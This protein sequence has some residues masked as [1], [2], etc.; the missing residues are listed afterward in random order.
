MRG[1][2]CSSFL[3][4][5]REACRGDGVVRT[6]ACVRVVRGGGDGHAVQEITEGRMPRGTLSWGAGRRKRRCFK[7]NG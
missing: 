4:A 5:M 2:A 6:S 3:C 7:S 1:T